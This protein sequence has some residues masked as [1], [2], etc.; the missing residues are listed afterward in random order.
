MKFQPA[1]QLIRKAAQEGY[2]IPSFCVWNAEI[3]DT[4][5][6]VASDC[7]APVM[8]M[9]GPSELA[10]LAPAQMAATARAIAAEYQVPAALHL[11]HSDSLPLVEQCLSAGYTSVMLDLS[12]EPFARNVAGLSRVVELARPADATVEGEIGTLGRIDEV[13]GEGGSQC[14][15]TDP[16]EAAA[17]ARETGVDMLAVAIGNAHGNYPTRPQLDFEL[18]GTLRE[19]AGIPLVLHGGSGTPEEDIQKA[20]SLGIAKVNI[21]SELVRAVRET[22]LERWGAR[23]S[24]WVPEA[25]VHATAAI[26][27][28]VEKW[29]R[30][31]GAFGKAR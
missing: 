6:R 18:L 16:Q 14:L 7:R 12:T 20:V 31:T 8:L 28:I 9:N 11:D 4:V 5:L 23:E 25:L 19:A 24:L 15:L 29:F 2:A 10:L 1:S 3:M 30:W 22:L 21:A 17:Y 13:T 27:P 26:E